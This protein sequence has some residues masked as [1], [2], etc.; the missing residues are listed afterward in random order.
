MRTPAPG[1][2]LDAWDAGDRLLVAVRE[3][4]FGG[5]LRAVVDCPS[6]G[7]PLE[8]ALPTSTLLAASAGPDAVEVEADGYRVRCR[9]L[10]PTD[11]A[12]AGATGSTDAARAVLLA[13]AVESAERDGRPVPADGLP[14]AVVAAVAAAL[15]EADPLADIELP[16]GCDACGAS[17]TRLFDI[18]SYLWQELAAWAAG[19]LAEVHALAS[20]YGWSE[21][22]ILSLPLRRR[23]V[24]LDLV[25]HG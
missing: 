14:D 7:L 3:R 4:L 16:I 23:R 20:A 18:G 15:A 21:A 9:A 13:R 6:C 19:L 5:T 11:L 12:D 17:W 8:V 10:R 24:Y 2:L 25:S 22:E 1:E